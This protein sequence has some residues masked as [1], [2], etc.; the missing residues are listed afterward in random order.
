[1]REKRLLN[2]SNGFSL[3]SP[4][5]QTL[6]LTVREVVQNERHHGM[7]IGMSPNLPEI[8]FVVDAVLNY[9]RKGVNV[10]QK[11]RHKI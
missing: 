8:V 1:M 7:T 3:I 5:F 2:N 10:V 11:P 6:S 9:V 4:P